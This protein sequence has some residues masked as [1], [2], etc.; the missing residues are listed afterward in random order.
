MAISI[1][2]PGA[3]L[4]SITVAKPQPTITVTPS[5]SATCRPDILLEEEDSHKT[6]VRREMSKHC[7]VVS[8]NV[9]K[10]SEV[11]MFSLLHEIRGVGKL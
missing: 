5:E 9:F 3:I 4:P 1:F 8:Q 10:I 11:F 7:I 6:A 2:F